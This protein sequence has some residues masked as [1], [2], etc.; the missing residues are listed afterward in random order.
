MTPE[1]E[2]T[3]NGQHFLEKAEEAL[4]EGDLVQASEKLWGAEAQSVKAIAQR[5]GW[6]HHSRKLLWRVVA[7]LANETGER[8]LHTL[9]HVANSLHTNFNEN[10]MTQE[11]V[12]QGMV[13]IR[14]LVL[15]LERVR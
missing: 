3:Q 2:Y 9:F 12:D 10:W 14:E 1:E 13:Q 5:R 4:R 7:R 15:R 8:D 11:F 6:Q